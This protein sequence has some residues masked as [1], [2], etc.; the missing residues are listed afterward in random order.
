MIYNLESK[1]DSS[2]ICSYLGNVLGR[3]PVMHRL[4][5]EVQKEETD[6]RYVIR[7][8]INGKY[9]A[10]PDISY[11]GLL[12]SG[13]VFPDAKSINEIAFISKYGYLKDDNYVEKV[14]ANLQLIEFY[15]ALEQHPL[16][17][18]LK[19]G[20]TMPF[21]EMAMANPLGIAMAYGL[22]TRLIPFTTNIDIARVMATCNYDIKK[23]AYRPVDQGY[24]VICVFLL[25]KS[26]IREANAI[27]SFPYSLEVDRMN[28]FAL[29]PR[30]NIDILRYPFFKAF[31]FKL[32]GKDGFSALNK[33]PFELGYKGNLQDI[34]NKIMGETEFSQSTFDTFLKS[35]P[36]EDGEKCKAK[37]K[38]YG[39]N[40]S[41]ISSVSLKSL[42][43]CD[44]ITMWEEWCKNVR[45][46]SND[47]EYREW[48]MNIPKQYKYS[49][50][51]NM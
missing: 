18:L 12:F 14:K 51:F 50:Y 8:L 49:Q 23:N 39:I 29:M 15:N 6:N 24:G 11:Q 46:L 36:K 33:V 7:R 1:A 4:P 30:N 27:G 37:L 47:K 28:L 44:L 9:I 19:N 45:F 22:T 17:K 16:Y 35:N 32:Q 34:A 48:L 13:M 26:F 2:K 25:P 42:G 38:K 31:A 43:N 5:D 41:D 21:G 3:Y 10:M 40:I 20:I